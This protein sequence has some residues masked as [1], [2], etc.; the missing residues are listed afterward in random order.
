[1]KPLCFVLM[2]FGRKPDGAGQMTDFDAV[3]RKI[4]APAVE[5]ADAPSRSVRISVM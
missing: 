4:I 5:A 2:P 1:M 3:Y